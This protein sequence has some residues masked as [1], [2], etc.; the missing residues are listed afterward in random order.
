MLRD[1]AQFVEEELFL[2][3][4]NEFYKSSAKLVRVLV[5]YEDATQGYVIK[6]YKLANGIIRIEGETTVSFT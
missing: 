5:P 6:A 3:I 4:A 1:A 2:M